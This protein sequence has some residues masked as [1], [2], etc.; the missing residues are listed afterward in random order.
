MARGDGGAVRF[1]EKRGDYRITVFTSPTPLR[2]GPVD[3]S[4]FVQNAATG[5]A[6]TAGEIIVRVAPRG[7][8]DDALQQ[9]ATTEAATNKLYRAAVF[10]LMESGWWD[11]DIKFEGLREPVQVRLEL[12]AGPQLPRWRSLWLW[13]GWPAVAIVLYAVHQWLVRR[14]SGADLHSV[15]S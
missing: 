15:N 8:P 9:L 13:I 3:I 1:S 6:V 5:E 10:E 11:V 14:T 4:V 2:A 12:E 7:R